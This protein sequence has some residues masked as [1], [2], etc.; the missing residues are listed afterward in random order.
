CLAKDPNDRPPTAEALADQLGLTLDQRRELPV[1]LQV[2]V[3]RQGRL[4]G[5]GGLLYVCSIPLVLGIVGQVLGRSAALWTFVG[6]LTIVP[7]GIL[8]NRARRFLVSGF[9][10]EELG[11]AFRAEFE[12]G[13]EERAFEFGRRRS[14]LAER[15]LWVL[16]GAGLA[17]AAGAAVILQ[18][19][20]YPSLTFARWLQLVAVLRWGGVGGLVS[21]FL[22]V[23]QLQRRLDL[24]TRLWT[25]LWRGAFGRLLFRVARW[26]VP[27]RAVP[28]AVTHRATE[29]A[30]AMAAAQLYEQLPRET[31]TQLRRLPD[32]V[33]RLEADAQR[34]R[35]R[36]DELQD[37]LAGPRA[38]TGP[39]RPT[40]P[41]PSGGPE[42]TS[43][44]RQA[45]IVEDL[46]RERDL[47]QERLGDAVR[48]LETIRL[49]LLRLHAGSGS[50]QSLTTDV[51]AARDVA[52]EIGR[53]LAARTEVDEAL[54]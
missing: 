48:A 17:S 24:D 45:R 36:V 47:I 40:G 35:R 9:S 15:V 54:R 30:L 43:V 3:K 2:F 38:T 14:S 5:V 19:S 20:T 10:P 46:E 16:C 29:L 44:A 21:G 13:R 42:D 11:A 39:T 33:H 26:F 52:E 41:A 31:R 1:G 4:G 32:V 50:V 34:L 51:G 53:L 22:A 25:W 8:V 23:V 49:N 6:A 28:P 18:T 37:A 7:F 12:R 27:R